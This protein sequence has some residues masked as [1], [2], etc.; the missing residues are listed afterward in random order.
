MVPELSS[1]ENR[2]YFWG[3]WLNSTMHCLELSAEDIKSTLHRV[4]IRMKR[5]LLYRETEPSSKK[6]AAPHVY[7]QQYFSVKISIRYIKRVF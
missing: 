4:K 3:N 2:A 7:I 5:N 6:T 1:T